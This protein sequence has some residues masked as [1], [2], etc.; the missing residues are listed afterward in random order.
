ML[1]EGNVLYIRL[2]HIFQND[3]DIPVPKYYAVGYLAPLVIVG[4]TYGISEGLEQNG[5]GRG[6]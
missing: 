2:V 1:L 6:E 5:Y 4:T 3:Q